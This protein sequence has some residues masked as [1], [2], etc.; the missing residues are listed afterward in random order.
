MKDQLTDCTS[1]LYNTLQELSDEVQKLRQKADRI[2]MLQRCLVY[3]IQNDR[4]TEQEQ[5]D[6][7]IAWVHHTDLSV[8]TIL[9]LIR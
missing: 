5:V 2:Y 9:T 7:A 1:V 6:C 8:E 4:I 3:D